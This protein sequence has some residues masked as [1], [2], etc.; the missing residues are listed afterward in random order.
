MFPHITGVERMIY[1]STGSWTADCRVSV[2]KK[3]ASSFIL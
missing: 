3:F 1:T 2:R